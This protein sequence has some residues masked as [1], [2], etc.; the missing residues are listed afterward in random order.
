MVKLGEANPPGQTQ[1][2]GGSGD[3]WRKGE[4]RMGARLVPGEPKELLGGKNNDLRGPKA[5]QVV[6]SHTGPPWI[7]RARF[8]RKWWRW[9]DLNPRPP[10]FCV[11]RL[12][13]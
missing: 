10:G 1:S 2:P 13:V 6:K 5:S 7:R 3:A 12:P 11:P 4:S 8:M 9:R